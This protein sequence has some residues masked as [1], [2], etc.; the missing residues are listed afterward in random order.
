MSTKLNWRI[1][2]ATAVSLAVFAACVHNQKSAQDANSKQVIA[3]Q[4]KA[5]AAQKAKEIDALKAEVKK[6]TELAKQ[7]EAKLPKLLTESDSRLRLAQQY[8]NNVAK[9]KD[10]KQKLELQQRATKAQAEADAKGQEIIATRT[11]MFTALDHVRVLNGEIKTL[12]AQKEQAE[13]IAAGKP[14][15]EKVAKLDAD[16]KKKLKRSKR[17]TQFAAKN[18]E[19]KRM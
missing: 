16:S 7:L 19:K 5:E 17:D 10:S 18:D 3:Q 14:A 9:S 11:Q 12:T 8:Q 13:R 2:T 15:I 1:L 4:K 6:E